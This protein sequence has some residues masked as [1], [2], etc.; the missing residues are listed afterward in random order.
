M[1][2]KP[3]KIVIAA[4]L[5]P[6]EES[7]EI[8][9]K[10]RQKFLSGKGD[11]IDKKRIGDNIEISHLTTN[12]IIERKIDNLIEYVKCNV[13]GCEYQNDLYKPVFTNYGGRVKIIKTCSNTCQEDLIEI[14]G[15]GRAGKTKKQLIP[16]RLFRS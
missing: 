14:C 2:N 15:E 7:S 4:G 9:I 1:R 12:I 3:I 6:M 10:L 11:Q 13:C 16:I 5:T 8:A